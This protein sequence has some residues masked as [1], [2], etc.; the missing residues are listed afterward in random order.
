LNS[1]RPSW[2]KIVG[3][4]IIASTILGGASTITGGLA[5]APDAFQNVNKAIEYI[6]GL[7][8]RPHIQRPTL[9]PTNFDIVET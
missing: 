1:Q 8:R 7:A 3:A 2:S 6:L 4:L 9:P 5:D